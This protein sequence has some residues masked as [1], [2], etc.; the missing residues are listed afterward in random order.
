MLRSALIRESFCRGIAPALRSS[1]ALAIVIVICAQGCKRAAPEPESTSEPSPAAAPSPPQEA[2]PAAA[3][4]PPSAATEAAPPPAEL[5]QHG[6]E[7]YARMCAVCHGAAGEGYKADQAPALAQPDFLA[8]VSD[9]LLGFAIAEGRKGTTMSAWFVDRGGPLA[10]PD[11][12]ALIAFIRSWQHGPRA[13]LDDRPVTGDAT[14]GK[15]TFAR[16][17][18]RCHGLK[19]PNVRIQAREL[20]AHTTPGFLRYAIRKGRPPTPMPG[21]EKSLGDAGIED[22]VAYLRSLPSWPTPGEPPVASRPPPLPLGPV[23]LNPSGPEPT[24]FNAYP[25][26]TSVDVVQSQLS[27]N[28]RMVLLDARVPTDYAEMHIAGA[29]SVPFYDPAPYLKLLPK[30]SWMVCYCGCPHAESGALAEKLTNAGFSKVT[31]L[32]EGLGVWAERRYPMRSGTAP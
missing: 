17:C 22:V 14:R 31:V 23:P 13:V 6:A 27:R 25:A 5:V 28:A 24:G 9:D 18:A 29:V 19:G 20:L 1:A 15:A 32:D 7:L 4:A 3:P 30:Q 21:F 8:S 2:P 16:E 10:V 12:Q 11:I 26:M